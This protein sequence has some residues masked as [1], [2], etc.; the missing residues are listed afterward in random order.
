[1]KLFYITD[2]AVVLFDLLQHIELESKMGLNVNWHA[3]S[4]IFIGY[5]VRYKARVVRQ[6]EKQ[7][8]LDVIVPNY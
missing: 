4:E 6:R 8:R 5:T 1:M 3:E 2:I 7:A